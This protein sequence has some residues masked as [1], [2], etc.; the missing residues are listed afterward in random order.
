VT[1]APLCPY[2]G[3]P[4]FE[5]TRVVVQRV[6]VEPDLEDTDDEVDDEMAQWG[7]L[8]GALFLILVSAGFIGF[9][10]WAS[11][12]CAPNGICGNGTAVVGIVAGVIFLLVAIGLLVSWIR[13]RPTAAR[14]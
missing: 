10:L 2:C 13:T 5:P 4:V 11:S 8:A 9:S 6:N 7:R 14:L 3:T 12:T 1:D